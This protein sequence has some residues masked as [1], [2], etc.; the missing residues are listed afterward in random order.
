M[1]MTIGMNMMRTMTPAGMTRR[2][3][4]LLLSGVSRGKH[5][6]QL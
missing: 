3:T 2:K 4:T 5:H 1:T 6:Q